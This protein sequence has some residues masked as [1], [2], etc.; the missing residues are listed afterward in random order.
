M[1]RTDS[2]GTDIT[3]Q[4]HIGTSSN[5]FSAIDGAA[6]N[7]GGS[8]TCVTRA[9]QSIS[10]LFHDH[11]PMPVFDLSHIQ[12]KKGRQIPVLKRPYTSKK[13]RREYVS[14]TTYPNLLEKG[15]RG[16]RQPKRICCSR[17]NRRG[18]NM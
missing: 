12:K 13:L 11:G 3:G 6:A 16:K 7:F 1:D 4:T 14:F 17:R 18:G 2:T 8:I 5:P 15:K 10:H 9:I